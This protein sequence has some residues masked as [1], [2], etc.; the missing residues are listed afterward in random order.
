MYCIV[1][2]DLGSLDKVFSSPL[3]K[4]HDFWSYGSLAALRRVNRVSRPEGRS[5]GGSCEN[6]DWKRRDSDGERTFICSLRLDTLKGV[7]K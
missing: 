3:L 2:T 5:G 7:F 6:E 1:R 4:V